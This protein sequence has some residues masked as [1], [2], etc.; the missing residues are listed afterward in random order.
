MVLIEADA[1]GLDADR[2]VEPTLAMPGDAIERPF[3]DG[4]PD[5]L[6]PPQVPGNCAITGTAMAERTPE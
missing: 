2:G 4:P 1:S 5:P 6:R 3:G